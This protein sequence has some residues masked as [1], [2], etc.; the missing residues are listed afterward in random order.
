[1]PSVWPVVP[2]RVPRPDNDAPH[3]RRW[4]RRAALRT[5]PPGSVRSSRGEFQPALSFRQDPESESP[6]RRPGQV[7]PGRLPSSIATYHIGVGAPRCRRRRRPCQVAPARVPASTVLPAGSSIRVLMPSVWPVVPGRVPQ[8][9]SD[10]PHRCPCD[11]R[12]A[13][14]DGAAWQWQVAPALLCQIRL[15]APQWRRGGVGSAARCGQPAAAG[16]KLRCRRPHRRRRPFDTG[17][18]ITRPGT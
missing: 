10:V 6:C 8:P 1:M 4:D 13:L 9:D 17:G 12:A 18:R 14:P 3:R 2:G 15:R 5:E 7:V 16:R 11:L